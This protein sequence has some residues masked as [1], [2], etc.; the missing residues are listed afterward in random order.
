MDKLEEM[1]NNLK[2]EAIQTD[3]HKCRF[4]H[5]YHSIQV[6]HPDIKL[7]WEQIDIKHD[8]LHKKAGEVIIAIENEDYSKSRLAYEEALKILHD[9]TNI[10][11]IIME[12]V[13]S[14]T[15]SNEEVFDL[16]DIEMSNKIVQIEM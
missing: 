16:N 9:I 12:K 5:F 15:D 7:E 10:F 3:G 8:T 11:E 14:L 6:R 4:G 13:D 2:I 1:V